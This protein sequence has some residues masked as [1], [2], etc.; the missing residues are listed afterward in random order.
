MCSKILAL[1]SSTGPTTISTIELEKKSFKI[2][3]IDKYVGKTKKK[4]SEKFSENFLKFFFR[5]FSDFFF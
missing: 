5:F 3:S 1:D 4:G 2:Y